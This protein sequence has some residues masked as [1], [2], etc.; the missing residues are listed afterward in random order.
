MLP[1]VWDV[2]CVVRPIG[3]SWCLPTRQVNRLESEVKANPDL[4]LCSAGQTGE[5]AKVDQSVH[6]RSPFQ[7]VYRYGNLPLEKVHQ[8]DLPAVRP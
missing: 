4:A 6:Y 5:I 2:C 7:H 8:A 3:V 1:S